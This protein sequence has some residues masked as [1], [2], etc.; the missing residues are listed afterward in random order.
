MAQINRKQFFQNLASEA[1][2]E[3]E[4]PIYPYKDPSNTKVPNSLR[5]TS[6]GINP[7]QGTWTETEIKHLCRRTLFGVSRADIDFFRTKTMAQAVDAILNTPTTDPTPPVNH[8][9]ANTN[10]PDAE[11]ALGQTWVNAN[12]NGLLSGAR[13]TS[14]KAWWMGLMIN[15]ERNIREKMTLFWHHHFATESSII[16]LARFT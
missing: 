10:F 7:Y 13:R 5:K 9:S 11:V 1:L 14:F 12:E 3:K 6:T 16:Q 2:T 4:L 8:Y 15:Q